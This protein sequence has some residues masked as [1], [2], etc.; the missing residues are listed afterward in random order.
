MILFGLISTIFD[1]LLF[2]VLLVLFQASEA[3]FQSTWFV[4]SLLTELRVVFILRTHL[5]VG[6]SWPSRPGRLL[7][8]SSGFV[9][10]LAIAL[11]YSGPVARL[12]SLVPI[13]AS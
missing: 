12:F 2:F 4:V 9:A 1:L 5:P 3:L 6:R 8:I 10:A 11:P 13:P 7:V